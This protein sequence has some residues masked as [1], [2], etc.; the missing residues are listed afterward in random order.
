MMINPFDVMLQYM[1]GYL[2]YH[3]TVKAL[4]Q[5]EDQ[6]LADIGLA[7]NDIPFVAWQACSCDPNLTIET[8]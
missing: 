5:L 3:N 2:R 6:D 8:Y 4:N 7:R 1:K